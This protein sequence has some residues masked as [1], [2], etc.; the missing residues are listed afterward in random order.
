MFNWE[1][2]FVWLDDVVIDVES[3]IS[4]SISPTSGNV[5]VPVVPNNSE[6]SGTANVVI[7]GN[8]SNNNNSPG[9]EE[10]D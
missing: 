10:G 3:G 7:D 5:D 1:F 9:N 6:I 8:D 2:N 4:P